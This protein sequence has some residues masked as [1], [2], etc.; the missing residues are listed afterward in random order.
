MV[1]DVLYRSIQAGYPEAF[2]ILT[3]E[4]RDQTM[5]RAGAQ[6]DFEMSFSRA[7][8]RDD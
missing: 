2:E 6:V 1:S 4:W 5:K 8:K 3:D 7:V